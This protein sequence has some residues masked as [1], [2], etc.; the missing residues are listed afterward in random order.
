MSLH[1]P[2]RRART[3]SA[4]SDGS[5]VVR[6][7]RFNS[8]EFFLQQQQLSPTQQPAQ[9]YDSA[10]LLEEFDDEDHDEQMDHLMPL[11]Y[12]RSKK[13]MGASFTIFF[14]A[15]ASLIVVIQFS[16]TTVFLAMGW[17][18]T[19]IISSSSHDHVDSSDSFHSSGSHWWHGKL[20]TWTVTNAAHLLVTIIYIH[21]LKGSFLLDEQGELNAMTTW[22]QLE[23]VPYAKNNVAV[24]R[25]LLTVPTARWVI[26]ETAF[27]D[28]KVA[29]AGFCAH[30]VPPNAADSRSAWM[31]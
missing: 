1:T 23:A 8:R 24:R 20:T 25:T 27:T 18:G 5:G 4:D 21:W 28:G 22:E 19:S 12:G 7:T 3:N 9:K 29:S 26:G 2:V 6:R 30:T 16:V 31:N 15:Y 14:S 11:E 17:G 10:R 13:M